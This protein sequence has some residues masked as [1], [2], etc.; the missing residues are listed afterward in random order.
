MQP[1]DDHTPSPGRYCFVT[2]GRAGS[3][4]GTYDVD[5]G[6]TTLLSPIYDLHEYALVV[7]DYRRW[8]TNRRGANPYDDI[9][10]VSVRS[11]G[12]DWVP[13][14]Y[15]TACRENWSHQVH[16]LNDFI[17]RF[18]IDNVEGDPIVPVFASLADH[19]RL[20]LYIH[21]L[22]TDKITQHIHHLCRIVHTF[23]KRIKKFRVNSASDK[24]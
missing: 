24:N 2:D 22:S 13:L 3:G 15:T 11:A 23:F 10:E 7:V 4:A 1:E 14:E 20:S 16:I 19:F 21:S 12:A 9:W 5:G 17:E 8:Y 6:R 18:G